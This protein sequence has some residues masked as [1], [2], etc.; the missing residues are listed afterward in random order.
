ML[1][2]VFIRRPDQLFDFTA[3]FRRRFVEG[4]IFMLPAVFVRHPDGNGFLKVHDAPGGFA[5]GF[6]Q[7]KKF[8]PQAWRLDA[9]VAFRADL[10]CL[11]NWI[12]AFGTIHNRN[13]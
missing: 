13:I 10:R 9:C 8:Q 1:P 2:A 3:Q 5:G 12:T 6:E 7:R 11:L 4:M